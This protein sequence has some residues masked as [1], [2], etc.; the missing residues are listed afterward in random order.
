MSSPF[1]S[2]KF[3]TIHSILCDISS[4]LQCDKAEHMISIVNWIVQP[5]AYMYYIVQTLVY[6]TGS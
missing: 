5:L 1:H 6:S 4:N 3:E 2:Q